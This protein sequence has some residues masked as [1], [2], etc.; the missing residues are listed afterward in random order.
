MDVEALKTKYPIINWEIYTKDTRKYWKIIRVRNHTEV[1]Q[2]FEDMLKIFDMD[3][4]VMLWSLVKERF[5]S[6]KP[7][8]DRERVLWVELKML[9]EHDTTEDEL[10]KLQRF[11]FRR[12]SLTGFPAQSIRS[13]NAIAL[14]LPYLLVLITGTSQSRQHGKSKSDS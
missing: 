4:L 12:T 7:I 9:F 13:S 1:Y 3:D 8:D 6:T 10:W 11:N 14:D 2:F 5:S